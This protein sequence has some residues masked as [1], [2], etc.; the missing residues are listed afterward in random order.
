MSHFKLK[1]LEGFSKHTLFALNVPAKDNSEIVSSV[2]NL[3]E[4]W[5]LIKVWGSPKL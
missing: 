1:S 5:N 4:L 3:L 2:K